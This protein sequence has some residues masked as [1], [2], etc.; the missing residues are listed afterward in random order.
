LA[1][2]LYITFNTKELF[3]QDSVSIDKFSRKG[4]QMFFGPKV[5]NKFFTHLILTLCFT[6]LITIAFL[7]I[8]AIPTYAASKIDLASSSVIAHIAAGSSPSVV[9]ISTT[10]ETQKSPLS[11]FGAMGDNSTPAQGLGS[12]FFFD[13]KGFILTNAHV[14]SGAKTIEVLLKGQK[15]PFP[16]TLVGIDQDL[17]VA[18]IKIDPPQKMPCLKLGDS[19]KAQT[20]DWVVAIGNPYGLDHTVTLGIISAKGRPIV[21]GEGGNGQV[22]DDMLQTDAAINP[23]NSGGPLLNLDGEVIG[24]NAA[25]SASGQGLGFAIPINKVKDILDELKTKGKVSHPWI[26]VALIDL[27]NVRADVRSYL[28][29]TKTDG[30]LL[31]SVV[32]G[33]PAA[34]AGLR[35]YDVILEID[36]HAVDDSQELVD[37]IRHHKVGDKVNLLI[38]R[39]GDLI[40]VEVT[41]DEKPQ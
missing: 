20:G 41:L 26:G 5:R 34:E 31:Q 24:I 23:G 15:N 40:K 37:G 29:I 1:L 19:D 30:V 32:N 12:G 16:A 28:G 2:I 6:L 33:S 35:Q 27:K 25:V 8:N 39:K 10:Y 38:L 11:V 21:A 18:I 9:W 7:G 22:Y 36:H 4:D 3:W 14:V 17:D 13:D